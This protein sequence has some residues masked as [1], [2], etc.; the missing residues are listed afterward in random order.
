VSNLNVVNLLNKPYRNHPVMK[1]REVII[2]F[3]RD[4]DLS[5]CL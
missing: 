5:G 3:T 2:L 4:M 1:W